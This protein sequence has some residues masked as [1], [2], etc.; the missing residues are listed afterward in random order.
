MGSEGLT[1]LDP[2]AD[3]DAVLADLD[4]LALVPP[5]DIATVAS[6]V[7]WWTLDAGAELFHQGDSAAEMF[8][9]V[10]GRLESYV[11]SDLPGEHS[12]L[13]E[14][15]RGGTVGE[16]AILVGGRRTAT[17]RA[18]RDS[19]LV[20][21]PE[22]RVSVLAARSPQLALGLARLVATRAAGGPRAVRSA[23]AAATIAVINLDRSGAASGLADQVSERLARLVSVRRVTA[24][25]VDGWVD[26]G[27]PVEVTRRLADAEDE[28]DVVL[29]SLPDLDTFLR[30]NDGAGSGPRA[31][32]VALLLRQMD[33][34]VAVAAASGRP[35][36]EVLDLLAGVHRPVAIALQHRRGRSPSGT[37]RWLEQ[38]G[39]RCEVRGH[40]HLREGDV[41]DLDRLAR[42]L[43]GRSVGVVLGGG[44]SRGFAHI[45]VLRAMREAGLCVD[46]VGGSSMG[47]IMGAQVAMGWSPDEM[48][49]RNVAAWS[50]RNFIEL[51]VPTLSLLRGRGAIKILDLFFG[52]RQIE[53]LWLDYFCATVDLS[54]CRLHIAEEGPVVDWVRASA[55]VPGLWPPL[56]DADGHLHVD[57]GML[58]NVPTDIMRSSHSG[59]VIGI[60]VCH[61]QSAMR[62][63]PDV[64]LPGGM[65]LVRARNRGQWFPSIFDV[66]NRSNLLAS[67][68]QHEQAER[69]ADLYMTPPAEDQGFAAFD[70]V[71]EIADIGYR[72]AV[73][74]LEETDLSRFG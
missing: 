17:V 30:G 56:V 7:D 15:G 68:Q 47:A 13:G 67:L 31:A 37:L 2:P 20:R 73:Q 5:E 40:T 32:I 60:D 41:G 16:T 39:A 50:K 46:R 29:L 33:A 11:E 12:V 66:M 44:G 38:V 21:L 10:R 74:V 6:V 71:G 69:Y 28:L 18:L 4:L 63:P 45:G 53:D 35:D 25:D 49:E 61:R 42:S 48:L 24:E 34:V 3:A 58:D 27:G 57:G 19:I 22:D 14:I 9:V 8:L 64:P 62:V 43:I 26:A 23:P 54:S 51:N 70:R 59:S 36:P 52:D 1:P 65:S 55:T 72:Y